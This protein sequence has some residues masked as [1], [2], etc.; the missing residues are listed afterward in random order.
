MADTQARRD[1]A[2][3]SVALTQEL[4]EFLIELSIALHRHAMY[5]QGHP[6]LAP[7]A[8]GV[9]DRLTA[10]L[11]RR[12]NLSLGVARRQLVIEGVATDP[13][14]PVLRDLASR[15]HKHHIGAVRF[16]QGTDVGELTDVLRVLAVDAERGEPLGTGPAE[17][18]RAWQHITLY[19]LTYGQLELVDDSPEAEGQ[20]ERSGRGANAARL[21]I[22]LARAA[23]K[24]PAEQDVETSE[25]SAVAKAINTH[26]RAAAYD[27]VIVG[28]MLQIAEELKADGG[29]ASLA[30]RRRISAMIGELDQGTL[31]RLVEMSGDVAQRSRFVDDASRVFAADAVVDVV[32]AAAN[33]SGQNISHSMLRLLS[34]LA[35]HADRGAADAR[36]RADSELREQVRR[37][38]S[39][40]TLEDPNPDAYTLALQSMA[41]TAPLTGGAHAIETEDE[42]ERMVVMG[43]E[44]G[45]YGEPVAS[46]AERMVADGGLARLLGLLDDAAETDASMAL[47]AQLATPHVLE[48]ELKRSG[49]DLAGLP[50]LI[51]RVGDAAMPVLLEAMESS[52]SRSV[53][54]ATLDMLAGFGERAAALAGRRLRSA[55]LPWY[56]QRN[57]LALLAETGRWPEG[58]EPGPF[59]NHADARVRREAYRVLFAVPAERD[60]AVCA[61]L[62]DPDGRNLRQGLA[63]ARAGLPAAGVP[64]VARRLAEEEL[65]DELRAQAVRTLEG[66]RLPLARDTLLRM[67][68][69][70]RTLLGGVRLEGGS[71]VVTAALGVLAG[72]WSADPTVAPVLAAAAK[73]RDA[74]IRRAAGGA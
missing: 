20:E 8:A 12:S 1:G 47:W 13:K 44:V 48:T 36:V 65:P 39:D 50:P 40:W 15:L 61:A 19:P 74:S 60:R 41:S 66:A 31:E 4:S 53:R 6:S 25:P 14:H 3:R 30:L 28:Y 21:W 51:E 29:A 34:K 59:L 5:P 68:V 72:T 69:A 73:S 54:R 9:V 46:A 10:L 52:E 2:D 58:L 57:L 33:A 16:E 17:A 35:N 49:A 63:A 18:L 71:P 56:V 45:A 11:S 62:N 7:A 23:L 67:V 55:E 26:E 22:G 42:P 37:L 64:L 43:L 24:A 27:Q 32:K 38:V 70:G